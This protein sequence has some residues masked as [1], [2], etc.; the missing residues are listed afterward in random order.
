MPKDDLGYAGHML[1]TARKAAGK[2]TGKTR[3]D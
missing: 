3:E 1:D 2:V